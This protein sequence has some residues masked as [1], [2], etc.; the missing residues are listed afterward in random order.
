MAKQ[1]DK[2]REV[3]FIDKRMYS[4]GEILEIC[5]LD[6]GVYILYYSKYNGTITIDDPRNLLVASI[7]AHYTSENSVFIRLKEQ[8]STEI[9]K[10]EIK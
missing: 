6:P 1:W 10:E 7:N 5:A 2:F 3:E 9:I 4:L 8:Y